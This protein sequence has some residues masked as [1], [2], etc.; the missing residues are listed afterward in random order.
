MMRTIFLA[1]L[2]L[3]C[4]GCLGYQAR[5]DM[6]DGVKTIAVDVFRNQT[7]YREVEFEFTN[8]L[9]RELSAKTPLRIETVAT[10]DAVITGDLVDYVRKVLRESQTDMPTEYRITL[11]VNYTV[12]NLKT[13]AVIA[14]AQRMRRSVEYQVLRGET[15]A[16]AR[17]E[18]TREL[19]RNVV[20][21]AFLRWELSA[22]PDAK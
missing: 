22:T 17:E 10:A 14:Q 3:L 4:T 7:L 2:L 19:A 20:Q 11:V 21:D 15:E 8:A 5:M 13:G 9:R 18:A 6:P 16:G 12:T 1:P